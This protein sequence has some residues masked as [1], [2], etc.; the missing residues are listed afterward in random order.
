M[1]HIIIPTSM[2][3]FPPLSDLHDRSS[4]IYGDEDNPHSNA[5][6]VGVE[7]GG[8]IIASVPDA[9]PAALP[10][11]CEAVTLEWSELVAAYPD[12]FPAREDGEWSPNSWS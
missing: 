5:V 3:L 7:S 1:T 12:H 2:I 6:Q 10:D 11:G 4:I 9:L 8:H